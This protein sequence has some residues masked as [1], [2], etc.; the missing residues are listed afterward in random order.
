MME[1]ELLDNTF[2][3]LEW[4]R[5]NFSKIR[6][7]YGGSFVAIKDQKIIF[8]SKNKEDIFKRLESMNIKLEDV[9]VEYIPLKNEIMIL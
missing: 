2:S 9:L 4:L 8:S 3:D 7:K 6:Q 1:L 5:N